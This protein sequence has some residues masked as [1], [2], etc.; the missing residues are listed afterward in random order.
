MEVHKY[1]ETHIGENSCLAPLLVH[2]IIWILDFS[3]DSPTHPCTVSLCD[4]V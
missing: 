2:M 1:L 3:S 4:L